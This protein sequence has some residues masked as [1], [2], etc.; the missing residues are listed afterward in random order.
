MEHI[1][2]ALEIARQERDAAAADRG[3]ISFQ[4]PTAVAKPIHKP[5][6]AEE[7]VYTQ[8]KTVAVSREFLYRQRII[9]GLGPG[10]FRDSYKVLRTKVL[11]RLQERNEN[12]LAVTSPTAGAGSTLTAINLAISLAMDVSRTVLLVDANLC[13]PKVH[14]YFGLNV[15]VGLSDYLTGDIPVEQ[16]LVHPNIERFVILPAGKPL[17]NSSEMLIS[18]QMVHLVD[19]LKARYPSRIVLFDLPALL[20]TDDALA[21]L[22]SVESVLLVVEKGK[23]QTDELMRAVNLVKGA[24]VHLVGTILNKSE[25]VYS[26]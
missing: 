17:I 16:I 1:K 10:K 24:G 4:Q 19:E 9:A 3:A 8:T 15:E 20:P 11:Q 12:I 14:A 5:P 18:P 23:T 6:R 22:P 26:P 7:I 2:K 25:K 21:F 13:Q